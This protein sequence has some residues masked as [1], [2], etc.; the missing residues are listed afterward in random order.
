MRIT[1]TGIFIFISAYLFSQNEVIYIWSG[2][3]TSNS[4]KVNAKMSNQSSTIRLVAATDSLFTSP[5]YSIFYRVDS[6][7]NYMVS[8]D[9]DGLSPQ[10]KY[11]YAVE[12]GGIIDS[13]SDDIGSF[14][15]FAN[16]PFSYSFVLGSCSN[17][18]D[19]KV[20]DVMKSM[21]PSFYLNMGDLHYDNPNS[22][23]NINVHRLPYEVSV[24]SHARV[25]GL[26]KKVPI[27]Y[28]WDDHDFCGNGSDS[29]FSG[30][31]NARI[32]YHEYVP[33]YPLAFGTGAS[34]PISQSF[35]IGRIHFIMTDL[36][37]VR[38]SDFLLGTPEQRAWFES[39]CIYARDNHLIV[40]WVST[41]SWS[42]ASPWDNWGSFAP[43]RTEISDF[44]FNN[45]I[46]NLFILSGDAHMLAIDNGSNA[47]YTT[48]L[49]SPYRYPIF[50]AAALNQNGSYKGGTYSE[51]GYFPNPLYTFG[52][53]GLVNVNDS[54][55]DSIC[56]SF[57]GYRVD[58]SVAA[59]VTMLNSYNFCRNLN[60]NVSVPEKKLID[61]I[62]IQPNPA[63]SLSIV[64][65]EEIVLRSLKIYSVTGALV[66]SENKINER[67]M[68]YS[69]MK[70]NFKPGCYIV[71]IETDKGVVKKYWVKQ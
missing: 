14:T 67:K 17:S 38:N 23:T 59:T 51:G 24:L 6:T 3:L 5:V 10:T 52:Q 36:R 53:F 64:F 55:G 46:E 58:S 9:L 65:K 7:T 48:T 54:G 37:S 49:S 30:K 40:A 8:M 44:L 12:S 25:A 26:L 29:S 66:Y 27:A 15:T 41:D 47:D 61:N 1:L 18:S 60:Y 19:H 35:T 71:Q 31:A 11:F 21:S 34:Y 62:S 28:M 57:K 69:A 22:S 39:E 2:A 43:E 63:E 50:Q 16:G 56:I 13:S 32:A 42:G 45:Q 33:H 68:N 70:S 4:I 20:Y